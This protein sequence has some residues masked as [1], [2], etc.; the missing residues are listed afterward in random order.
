MINFVRLRC[1]A[2]RFQ[3]GVLRYPATLLPKLLKRTTRR[4]FLR[5]T[6]TFTAGFGTLI[7]I[8]Q[9]G[10]Q[11]SAIS[12]VDDATFLRL[13]KAVT[14]NTDLEAVTASRLL[15]ALRR[16]DPAFIDHAAALARLV[17][18][19]QTPEALLIAARAVGLDE[20]V[21][22]LVAAWYTGTVGHGQQAE[23]VSYADALMYRAVSDGL[24]VPTYCLNGPL[25]WLG[26]PPAAGV[27]IP[28][29]TEIT[30]PFTPN[31]TA[32]SKRG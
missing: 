6:A 18:D 32:P 12:T 2:T 26:S 15:I 10:S 23:M 21:I 19:G 30:P 16:A 27:G 4:T 25:G 29:R 13:S 14:G 31:P 24:P 17:Q 1:S 28:S 8:P 7:G 20:T 3:Q 5:A 9:A 22:A 11:Q